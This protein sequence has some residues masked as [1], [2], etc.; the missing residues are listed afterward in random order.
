MHS[1][2]L[3]SGLALLLI[4]SVVFVAAPAFAQVERSALEEIE[5]ALGEADVNA[6]NERA[7]ERVELT[8]FGS[9]AMYSRG[10][11][12]YVLAE[13]FRE[14]PPRRVDFSDPSR[15]GGNWFALGQYHYERGENPLRVF[16]RLR[17]N[18]GQWQLRE[19]R[20]ERPASP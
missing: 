20:I 11:A 5:A 17:S 3:I 12:M 19:V 10:Q 8:L 1:F 2:R 13:F 9:A 18:G 6:L 7:A 14:Y 4:A 15:S 16:I